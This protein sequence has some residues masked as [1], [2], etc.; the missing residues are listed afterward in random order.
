[1]QGKRAHLLIGDDVESSKNSMTQL[2]RDQLLEKTR[3]FISINRDG[4]ILYLGTPQSTDS[5]YNTLPGRGYTIR[6]W[7]GRFPTSIE[8]KNYNDHLAPLI[9]RQ[10]EK[11]PSLQSGAGVLGNRGKPTDALMMSEQQLC[12]REIDQGPAYFNL[13]YMLDTEL[14][15]A[16][17]FPLKA[18]D[19]MFMALDLDEAPGKFIWGPSPTTRLPLAPGDDLKVSLFSPANIH[20]E[21]FPYTTRLLALDPSGESKKA[22]DETGYAV[23]FVCNGYYF[24]M[25]VGG[26]QSASSPEGQDFITSLCRH[27]KINQVI[28][29]KNYGGGIFTNMIEGTMNANEIKA[30]I[31]EVWSSGQKEPRIIQSIEPVLAL[32]RVVFNK[33]IIHD[34]FKSVQH[35]PANIR[36]SYRFLVQLIKLTRD[37]GALIHDD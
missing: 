12:D 20:T 7:P 25:Q 5:I 37:R 36:N 32:H 16:D 28:V 15:D 1:M 9:R 14:A 18:Q 33:A 29:E 23:V 30:G 6:I 8:I 17:R 21:T 3:D 31:E 22:N 24:V 4:K 2:M 13:Q 34:D 35:Y 27:W 26:I 10:L 19:M 11:D